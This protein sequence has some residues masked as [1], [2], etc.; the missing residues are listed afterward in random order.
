MPLNLKLNLKVKCCYTTLSYRLRVVPSCRILPAYADTEGHGSAADVG[1]AY[2]NINAGGGE[3]VS[4]F[5]NLTLSGRNCLTRLV[6]EM[7]ELIL[8]L[9]GL[10][11]FV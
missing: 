11:L 4:V 6:P 1:G 2:W 10:F 9:I 8:K 3:Q 5:T 7:P